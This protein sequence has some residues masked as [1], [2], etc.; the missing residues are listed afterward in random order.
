VLKWP[1]YYG[2]VALEVM[3]PALSLVPRFGFCNS[4]I[5]R[6]ACGQVPQNPK[7][8]KTNWNQGTFFN[9]VM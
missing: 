5:K 6:G 1:R 4:S 3:V 8:E 9:F 7:K 2:V